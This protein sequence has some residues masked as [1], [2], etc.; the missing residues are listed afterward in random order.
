LVESSEGDGA[1]PAR[2]P[3]TAADRVPAQRP[4][5]QVTQGRHWKSRPQ[6]SRPQETSDVAATKQ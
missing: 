2:A 3:E 4:W 1:A 6:E 5:K